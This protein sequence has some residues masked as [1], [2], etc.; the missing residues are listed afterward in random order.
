VIRNLTG[1]RIKIQ[2]K[3][4]GPES[5][6]IIPPFGQRNIT[7]SERLVYD[8]DSWSRQLLVQVEP[9]VAAPR[10]GSSA[11]L[12][13]CPMFAGYAFLGF[14]ISLTIWAMWTPDDRLL[15]AAAGLLA[16]TLGC[17]VAS[18]RWG[19]YLGEAWGRMRR[20][21]TVFVVVLI[22]A[23]LPL[24]TMISIRAKSSEATSRDVFGYGGIPLLL[25]LC[26]ASILPAALYY[27]FHRQ[28]LPVLRENFLRDIVRLDPYVQTLADA[29][30]TYSD[31]I[32]DVYGPCPTGSRTTLS[33]RTTPPAWGG[34]PIVIVT[35]VFAGLW[36]WTLLAGVEQR[37]DAVLLQREAAA[38]ASGKQP[39]PDV[40]QNIGTFMEQVPT[41]KEDPPDIASLLTPGNNVVTF[42]F[43]GSYFFALNML[44]RRYARSDLSPKAYT[45]VLVRT[46]TAIVVAWALSYGPGLQTDGKPNPTMLLLA[47]LIGIVPETGT[48]IIQDFLQS[49]PLVGK[50][51]PSLQEEHPLSKLDGISLYDRSQLLEVGIENIE[52]LAHNNLVDLMLWTRIPTS[53]LVDFVDQ[54]VLYL[55]VRGPAARDHAGDDGALGLLAQHGIRTATDLE[56]SFRLAQDKEAFLALL[57]GEAAKLHRLRVVLDAFADDEWMVCLRNWRSQN[58]IAAPLSSVD[59]FVAAADRGATGPPMAGPLAELDVPNAQGGHNRTS[60]DPGTRELP[61]TAPP[62]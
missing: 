56:R 2:P 40:H 29:Q 27:W 7:D 57:D 37:E 1:K 61:V 36:T 18:W 46:L 10:K 28:K 51:V 21:A 48:A 52:S 15:W 14:L 17:S 55:H 8:H 32:D 54:A 49:V 33:R 9:L 60:A 11:F 38:A 22:G 53:R 47:F 59:E 39:I 3:Q 13:L 26:T 35:L 31:L 62:G 50:R 24:T 58:L 30:T 43:L 12:G 34:I 20:S 5:G 16:A 19:K 41:Y 25:V 6:L 42:A 4:E 45:N 44:F 23:G